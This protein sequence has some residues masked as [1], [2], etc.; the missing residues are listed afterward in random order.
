[1]EEVVEDVDKMNIADDVLKDKSTEE[2]IKESPEE[3]AER[4]LDERKTREQLLTDEQ[5][6]KIEQECEEFKKQGNEHF[7]N[8]RWK[9]AE[10]FYSRAIDHSLLSMKEKVAVYYSNR[11]AAKI[12]RELWESAIEDCNKAEELGAPNDKPLERRAYARLHSGDDKM[13]DGALEDYKKLLE[14]KPNNKQYQQ[15]ISELQSKITERNEKMKQEMF[16]QLKNLGNM[17]LKPFGLSTDNFQ[18]VEQ[19]GG[20]YSI[21]MKK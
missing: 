2:E 16:S 17:C 1:M 18:L 5:R 19:P 9:E 11:A 3:K 4:E 6:Q 7:G 21:N 20:G 8:G 14:G 10:D 12:K 15:T 13:L